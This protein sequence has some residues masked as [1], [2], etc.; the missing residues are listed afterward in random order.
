[1][2]EELLFVGDPRIFNLE[3]NPAPKSSLLFDKSFFFLRKK[4]KNYKKIHIEKRKEKKKDIE[5]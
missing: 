2:V 5:T 4:K 3:R 1:V